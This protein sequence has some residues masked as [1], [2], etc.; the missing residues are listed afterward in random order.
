[1]K[2]RFDRAA[3]RIGV[4]SGLVI[5]AG[6]QSSTDPTPTSTPSAS[7]SATNAAS[8]SPSVSASAEATASAGVEGEE[9][10]VFELAVGDCFGE[11]G[12]D[13]E[14]VLVVDCAA[15]HVYETFA[16]ID[17]PAGGSD[18]YPGSDDIL[19]YADD[20]CRDP[21]VDYVGHDYETSVYWIATLNPSEET[22]A[23]GDREIVC[24]LTLG[25]DREV[26]TGSAA[27]SGE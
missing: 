27:G 2:I 18:A 9:T 1:V 24:T 11:T 5:L 22:W 10:S 26:T 8:A 25:E 6:C 3:L 19:A 13:P 16:L 15:A 12:D 23:I 17:H 20:A 21:F 14:S 7:P 4:L